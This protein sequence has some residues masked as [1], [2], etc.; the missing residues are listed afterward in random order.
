MSKLSAD[1]SLL[2]FYAGHGVLDESSNEGYWLP[3]TAEPDRRSEWLSNDE[4]RNILVRTLTPAC[5]AIAPA[6]RGS[7][8]RPWISA[9]TRLTTDG[10]PSGAERDTSFDSTRTWDCAS[11]R[12]LTSHASTRY[13]YDYDYD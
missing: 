4:I 3:V 8:S 5:M 10:P 11:R 12:T 9:S 6:V 2:I 13:D 7:S 1:D